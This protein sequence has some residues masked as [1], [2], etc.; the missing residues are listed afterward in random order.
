MLQSLHFVA[1]EVMVL[2][3]VDDVCKNLI[4]FRFE[5]EKRHI[6]KTTKQKFCDEVNES[7]SIDTYILRGAV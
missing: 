5:R 7:C 4:G 3:T 1:V 6:L 2:D